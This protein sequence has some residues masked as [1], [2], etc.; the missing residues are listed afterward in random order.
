MPLKK[1]Y[2]PKTVSTNI[3]EMIKSGH[4]KEQAIAAALETARR[5]K[6][7]KPKK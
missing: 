1:G 4:P 2:G 3:R 6:K 5:S 7:K